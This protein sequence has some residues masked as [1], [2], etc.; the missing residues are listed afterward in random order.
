MTHH[1]ADDTHEEAGEG[2]LDELIRDAL[3]TDVEPASVKR[4]EDFWMNQSSRHVRRR[5]LRMVAPLAAAASLL[6]AAALLLSGDKEESR[7]QA[8]KP[9]EAASPEQDVPP[10]APADD[11]PEANLDEPVLA[12]R[13]PTDY[14]RLI[15]LAQTRGRM[16][17][18]PQSDEESLAQKVERVI[19][20]VQQEGVDAVLPESLASDL[21]SHEPNEV[22]T[23]LL[24]TLPESSMSRQVAVCR[25]L[26]AVGSQ[27]S[28]SELLKLSQSPSVSD[29]ALAAIEAI[30]GPG[31]WA[32]VIRRAPDRTTQA[33]IVRRLL[34]AES[35]P[36]LL[37][38]LSLCERR[39]AARRRDCRCAGSARAAN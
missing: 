31:R 19:T 35:R 39:S 23:I 28:V 34:S 22:E 25:L 2:A 13:A 11:S 37:A 7:Q 6:L 17:A 38:Y 20:K 36:A 9:R 1:D 30:V 24:E 10:L 29:K 8:Q 4:L 21:G 12:G 32:D 27:R 3:R 26:A 5:V 33:A 18:P 14:E 15:F 16:P